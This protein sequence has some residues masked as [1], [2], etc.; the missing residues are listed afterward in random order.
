M[1]PPVKV[2][3]ADSQRLFADA[4]GAA[5]R[6][7]HGLDVIEEY[8]GGGP[9]TVD[10]ILFYHPD[11]AL[12]DYWLVGMDAP[13][14][15]RMVLDRLPE[16]KIIV[17]SWFYS[18][19]QVH[20]SL[21]AGAVGFLPKSLEVKHLA[22]AVNRAQAGESPVYEKELEEIMAS[23]QKRES[24]AKESSQKLASL[25]PQEVRI[26]LLLS[27]GLPVKE[28]AAQLF[29]SVGTT[30]N[31]IQKILKKLDAHSQ[32]EAIAMAQQFGLIQGGRQP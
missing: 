2:L 7:Q 21:E 6:L 12:I 1:P 25:T 22:D 29:I 13:A 15:T 31:Y 5:L 11:V 24:A 3:V 19:E 28:I 26:L 4:L 18:T 16:T 23:I 14:V 32:V 17:L 30:R 9:E 10:W 20:L 27:L 8:P